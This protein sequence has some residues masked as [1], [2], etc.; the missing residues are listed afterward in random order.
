MTISVLY[1]TT[2]RILLVHCWV[3]PT[4]CLREARN[5]LD[6]QCNQQFWFVL[7]IYMVN[8][9]TALLS[10]AVA[11]ECDVVWQY[12]NADSIDANG[13]YNGDE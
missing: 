6:R 8:N 12:R 3:G 11:S 2:W 5:G 4:T 10:A 1:W 13:R 7:S 9:Q